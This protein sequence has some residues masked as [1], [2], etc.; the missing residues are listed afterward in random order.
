MAMRK[1]WLSLCLLWLLSWQQ[2]CCP[3]GTCFPSDQVV[4]LTNPLLFALRIDVCEQQQEYFEE[5]KYNMNT[6]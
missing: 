4:H 6:T 5:G 1:L 2:H 3:F